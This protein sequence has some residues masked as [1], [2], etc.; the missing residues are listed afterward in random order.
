[1]QPNGGTFKMLIDR[2]KLRKPIPLHSLVTIDSDCVFY[3][4]FWDGVAT[5]RSIYEN[6]GIVSGGY[7]FNVDGIS[8]DGINGLITIPYSSPSLAFT[9][10]F[11]LEMWWRLSVNSLAAIFSQGIV[12]YGGTNYKFNA[13]GGYNGGYIDCGVLGTGANQVYPGF[14]WKINHGGLVQGYNAFTQGLF[15]HSAITFDSVAGKIIYYINGVV[16][17]YGAHLQPS[18]PA[19]NLA[20][21]VLIGGQNGGASIS[22]GAIDVGEARIWKKVLSQSDITTIYNAT[23]DGYT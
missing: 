20:Y 12:A 7:S 18:T 11:T 10:S 21:P 22:Y 17:T 19:S 6:D 2:L 3:G 13:R 9:D 14:P 4:A 8:L 16:I 15:H 5:D 23:K 1:M